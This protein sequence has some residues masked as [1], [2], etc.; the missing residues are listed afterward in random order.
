MSDI[1]KGDPLEC[2]NYRGI[3]LANVGHKIFSKVL[4]RKLEPIVNENVRKYQCGFIAG[5]STSDQIFNLRQIMGKTSE[6]GIKIYYLFTDFKAAYDSINRQ[7]LCLAMRDMGIPD[8]LIR[9][10]KLTMTYNCAMVKLR[11]V[12]SRQF[13]IKEG[14]RQGDPLACLLFNISLENLIRDAAVETRGTIFNKSVQILA[15]ADDIVIIGCSL[16]VVKETFISKEKAAK[17]MGLTVNENKIT[18]MAL[19]DPAY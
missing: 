11:N 9:L 18:F 7:S 16:A 1:Q 5:K 2:R 19:N 8:K 13:D 17:E 15:Y 3:T 6:Y 4:F 10:T 14:V 12:L